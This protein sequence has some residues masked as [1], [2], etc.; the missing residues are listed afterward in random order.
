MR[1]LTSQQPNWASANYRGPGAIAS[2]S[3][4]IPVLRTNVTLIIEHVESR[5][6]T[7]L[8][9][10]EQLTVDSFKNVYLALHLLLRYHR[11]IIIML[12]QHVIDFK[13]NF[14]NRSDT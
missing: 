14:G 2:L 3:P 7:L 13:T 12:L 1:P 5:R 8:E 9:V 6:I 11:N 10:F 4:L